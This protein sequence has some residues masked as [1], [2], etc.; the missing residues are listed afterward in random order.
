[1]LNQDKARSRGRGGSSFEERAAP[2]KV[3]I[4]KDK[5]T[6]GSSEPHRPRSLTHAPSSH[7]KQA[8][9]E[10]E[11][12]TAP[13]SDMASQKKLKQKMT[14]V[15]NEYV[16]SL[17]EE[18]AHLSLTELEMPDLHFKLVS[19][20]L[21]AGAEAKT[22]EHRVA[23]ADILLLLKDKFNDLTD[24]DFAKGFKQTHIISLDLGK[25]FSFLLQNRRCLFRAARYFG[26]LPGCWSTNGFHD[27]TLRC[28]RCCSFERLP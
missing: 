15:L 7:A 8:V 17:E 27:W 3:L 19:F 21:Q 9:K 4:S 13:S 20:A 1:M 11:A 28:P 6:S 23:Y 14:L 2:K 22:V 26:G 24:D 5:E 16:A 18:E 10:E 25:H 12:E